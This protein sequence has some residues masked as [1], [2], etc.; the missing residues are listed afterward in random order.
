MGSSV[1][2]NWF[3]KGVLRELHYYD[4]GNLS[5]YPFIGSCWKLL[6]AAS[7]IRKCLGQID[8]LEEQFLQVSSSNI[9]AKKV[10]FRMTETML[11]AKSWRKFQNTSRKG[12]GWS[13]IHGKRPTS[14]KFS[15]AGWTFWWK[16]LVRSWTYW[17]S[18]LVLFVLG[19]KC[20]EKGVVGILILDI[21]GPVSSW[22][23]HRLQSD[24]PL[25][26][27]KWAPINER[28]NG[29]QWRGWMNL[30]SAQVL[31]M[32]PLLT[33][34]GFLGWKKLSNYFPREVLSIAK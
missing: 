23:V 6:E 27:A 29:L 18:H 10:L 26:N 32:T 19:S 20:L 33:F 17:K 13:E 22:R 11:P 34:W 24:K 15:F 25:I 21:P 5:F 8:L 2:G 7:S 9:L 4:W 14:F 16:V 31:K 3:N 12:Q 1:L 30:C 28:L